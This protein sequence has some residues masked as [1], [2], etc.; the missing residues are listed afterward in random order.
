MQY[1][2]E[3]L[4]TMVFAEFGGQTKCIMNNWKIENGAQ[5]WPQ[6]ILKQL[7]EWHVFC[8]QSGETL[9]A[10]P[11]Q[12]FQTRLNAKALWFSEIL[13]VFICLFF[14]NIFQKAKIEIKLKQGMGIE[15]KK[16]GTEAN[17]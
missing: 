4:K 10:A 15:E 7:K 17:I 1:S 2:Q 14:L 12:L 11:T 6:T 8:D 9:T 5:P 13:L 16:N 3:H